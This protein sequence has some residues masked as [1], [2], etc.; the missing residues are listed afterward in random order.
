[1]CPLAACKPKIWVP[2]LRLDA[3]IVG[4]SS[5]TESATLL[6]PDRRKKNT[7]GLMYI[8]V[9]SFLCELSATT[10]DSGFVGK[11]SITIL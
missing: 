10:R 9:L 2:S 11:M 8:I 1:M 5:A 3:I 4:L 6:P 7:Y